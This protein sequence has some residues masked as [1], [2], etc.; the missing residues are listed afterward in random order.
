MVDST[1]WR[2]RAF[3]TMAIV[4]IS[5][6]GLG[7]V[8]LSGLM[9]QRLRPAPLFPLLRTS[10]EEMNLY[11]I[12]ALVVLGL[13]GGLLTRLPV[14]AIALASI[15]TLPAA[16]FLEI[17]ADPNSHNMFPIELF[18]YL[19]LQIPALLGALVGYG[20]RRLLTGRQRPGT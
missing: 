16:M 17:V 3:D 9:A 15:A 10:V 13:L 2:R 5:L 12:A 6:L 1:G 7:C 14:F 18:I 4:V 11:T 19:L 20:A 8:L